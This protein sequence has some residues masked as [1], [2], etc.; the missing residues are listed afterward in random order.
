MV[1][2][3]QRE[4]NSETRNFPVQAPSLTHAHDRRKPP[5]PEVPR[6]NANIFHVVL[7]SNRENTI[8]QQKNIHILFEKK[9]TPVVIDFF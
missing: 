4:T 7:G 8:K 5:F 9:T 3:F 1:C 6:K 2:L